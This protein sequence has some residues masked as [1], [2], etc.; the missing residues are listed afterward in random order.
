MI[1]SMKTFHGDE[2]GATVL[3]T[4]VVFM[5]LMTLVYANVEV[6]LAFY[7]VNAAEKAAQAAARIAAAQSPIYIGTDM[8]DPVSGEVRDNIL[9]PVYVANGPS[10]FQPNGVPGCLTPNDAGWSCDGATIDG[11]ADCD[12]SRFGLLITELQRFYPSVE[13]DDVSISYRYIQLGF[14]GG[15]MVPEIQVSIAPR[16]LPVNLPSVLG[17]ATIGDDGSTGLGAAVSASLGEDMLG[18]GS[19]SAATLPAYSCS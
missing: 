17:F 14:A 5:P 10:C 13:C 16:E 11:D 7:A 3:E 9:N 1:R 12:A 19:A 2:R 8:V 15:P 6:I 18:F 4:M